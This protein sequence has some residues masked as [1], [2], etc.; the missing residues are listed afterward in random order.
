MR[1]YWVATAG[2][3]SLALTLVHV[4]GGGADV[5]GPILDSALDETLK[6]F[7]SVVWHMITACMLLSSAMLLTAA[8]CPSKRSIL[9]LIVIVQYGLFT[10]IFLFYGV[11]R[12]GSVFVMP[13]WIGFAIITALATIGLWNDKG[14]VRTK[15]KS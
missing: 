4:I 13:P 10:M 5:H 11:V 1:S 3:L 14:R 7:V 8:C 2:A 15:V 12:F 6:G 9:T